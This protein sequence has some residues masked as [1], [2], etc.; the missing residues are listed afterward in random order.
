MI[1][2]D[3]H[4]ADA[5]EGID[6]GRG[7]LRLGLRRVPERAALVPPP[8]EELQQSS[9][10]SN[11]IR[12]P[13][14]A[15]IERWREREGESV[16]GHRRRWRGSCG[17]RRRRRRRRARRARRLPAPSPPPR[18]RPCPAARPPPNPY[19]QNTEREREKAPSAPP[20]AAGAKQQVGA[21]HSPCEDGRGEGGS[22]W[23]R[24]GWERRGGRRAGARGGGG[25]AGFRAPRTAEETVC[26][27]LV[28]EP[29]H[30]EREREEGAIFRGACPPWRG[31][32]PFLSLCAAVGG[33]VFGVW[34]AHQT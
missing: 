2:G 24:H 30:R 4:D 3:L 17:C 16:R 34:V 32:S 5:G 31:F 7:A 6:G 26:A 11:Q 33:R 23:G 14:K 8:R 19:T 12:N 13:A 27:S 28:S 10:R 29:E 15:S 21:L 25:G 22:R 1:C 18:S 20:P 9:T